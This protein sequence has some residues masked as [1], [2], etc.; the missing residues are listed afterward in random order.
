M[1]PLRLGGC[2]VNQQLPKAAAPR[3]EGG[4]YVCISN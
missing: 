4:S 1:L 3:M 2:W